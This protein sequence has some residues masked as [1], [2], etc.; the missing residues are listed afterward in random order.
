MSQDDKL[1]KQLEDF[2][3]TIIKSLENLEKEFTEYID[4]TNKRIQNLEEKVHKMEALV[5]VSSK[6][7]LK[8]IESSSSPDN[9]RG[10]AHLTTPK[11]DQPIKEEGKIQAPVVSSITQPKAEAPSIVPR[12]PTEPR[13][14]ITEPTPTSTISAPPVPTPS[15]FRSVD[16]DEAPTPTTPES[17]IPEVPKPP[18]VSKDAKKPKK[19]DEDK[20]ELMSALKIIDSL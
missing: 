8:A 19:E 3:S 5:D 6:G 18:T 20:D 2:V 4:V 7:L 1:Y 15:S 14:Q 11:T 16:A 13:P 17:R 10:L 12:P 9:V